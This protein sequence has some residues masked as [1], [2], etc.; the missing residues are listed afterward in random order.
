MGDNF[1]L[2]FLHRHLRN[3]SSRSQVKTGNFAAM[4]NVWSCGGSCCPIAHTIF[5]MFEGIVIILLYFIASFT[6]I[7]SK[8]VV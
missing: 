3:C 2:F 7:T 8:D 1:A 4:Y 5:D 6:V